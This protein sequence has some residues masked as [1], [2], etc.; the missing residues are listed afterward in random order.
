[1]GAM[2]GKMHRT[3][4]SRQFQKKQC[5]D[6]ECPWR[7]GAWAIPET[8]SG[9]C[10]HY[11]TDEEKRKKF[12][13][14]LPSLLCTTCQCGNCTGADQSE[15]SAHMPAHTHTHTTHT[16]LFF[17]P[18]P[19]FTFFRCTGELAQE[20]PAYL[21]CRGVSL[22]EGAGATCATCGWA[23]RYPRCKAMESLE[24]MTYHVLQK[25]HT[26][27]HSCA[28]THTHTHTH[29]HHPH[30]AHTSPSE[31][32]DGSRPSWIG[33]LTLQRRRTS[34]YTTQHKTN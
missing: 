10:V 32:L 30:Q 13:P 1:M 11:L 9:R 4:T 31:P 23:N 12:T 24:A 18:F 34:R 14:L 15:G 26:H 2:H 21:K 20:E 29:T 25:A 28:H 5:D 8:F 22:E 19:S 16:F 27:T 33:L 17:I 6:D 3:P 7:R